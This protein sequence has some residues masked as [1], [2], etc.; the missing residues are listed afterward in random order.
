MLYSLQNPSETYCDEQNRLRNLKLA[1][2][3]IRISY[4]ATKFSCHYKL[5]HKTIPMASPSDLKRVRCRLGFFILLL[6]FFFFF[7]C[8]KGTCTSKEHY[9][10][11]NLLETGII[12][13]PNKFHLN[14]LTYS[15]QLSLVQIKPNSRV[16]L[17]PKLTKKQLYSQ[18]FKVSYESQQ[19]S[20][21][22]QSSQNQLHVFF[23]AKIN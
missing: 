8:G 4:P 5:L 12:K 2:I 13:W 7:F 18:N 20:Q 22:Q 15:V 16:I 9:K 17:S 6:T 11:K 14:L 19:T 10:H 3:L 21:S 1:F 23:S